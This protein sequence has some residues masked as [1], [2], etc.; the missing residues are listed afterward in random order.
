MLKRIVDCQWLIIGGVLFLTAGAKMVSF[1]LPPPLYDM[2]DPL[3]GMK[4][5][6]VMALAAIIEVAAGLLLIR[7]NTHWHLKALVSLV[8]GLT[9]IWYH[10]AGLILGVKRHC[11]CLGSVNKF[12]PLTDPI[13]IHALMG[14]SIYMIA[15]GFLGI[16]LIHNYSQSRQA[17]FGHK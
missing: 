16:L 11:P 3:L 13:L 12:T 15:T 8:L 7:R 17:L 2:R 4:V 9:F 6:T 10:L 5:N 1:V 14:F